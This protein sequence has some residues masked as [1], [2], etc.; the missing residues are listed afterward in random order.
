MGT[1]SKAPFLTFAA[2]RARVAWRRWYSSTPCETLSRT[3]FLFFL[4]SFDRAKGV[5]PPRLP[6]SV[7]QAQNCLRR[8]EVLRRPRRAGVLAWPSV[9]PPFWWGGFSGGNQAL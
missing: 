5:C 2:F 9:S 1:E 3:T 8:E 7:F 4:R 6:D